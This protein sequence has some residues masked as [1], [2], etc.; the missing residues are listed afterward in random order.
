M[1]QYLSPLFFYSNYSENIERYRKIIQ[2]R[3]N[4]VKDE[5]ARKFGNLVDSIPSRLEQIKKNQ[6]VS[7][8]IVDNCDD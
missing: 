6:G 8:S 4:A 5:S 3:I 1:I 2:Q 7:V